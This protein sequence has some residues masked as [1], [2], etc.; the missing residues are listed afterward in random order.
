[1]S[2]A[3]FLDWATMAVSL[4]NTI[5][6]LW[7]GLTVLLNAEQRTGGVWLAGGGLLLDG[8]FFICHTV[9]LGLGLETLGVDIA[10]WWYLGWVPV[11]LSPLIWYLIMLWYAGFWDDRTSSLYRRHRIWLA[12]LVITAAILLSLLVIAPPLGSITQV[13]QLD[14]DVTPALGGI[15]VLVIIY[16]LYSMACIGL[17]IDALLRPA[18]TTRIR[19]SLA[20]RRAQR[21]LVADSAVI[22]VIVALV[23]FVMAWVVVTQNRNMITP[24]LA[25]E[26]GIL[27]AWF[28]LI[29]ASLIAVALILL[30]RA[31][32]SF[33]V[34]TGKTLPRGGFLRYW[35]NAIVLA[36]GYGLFVGWSLALRQDAIYAV[37]LTT[38][39]L[40][41]FYALA[42]WRAYRRREHFIQQ[43]RPF[44]S[45][46]SIVDQ[47]L[48]NGDTTSP[49][50][51]IASPFQM[52]C[53]DVLEAHCG[54]L[55]AVGP[56]APLMGEPIRY[57]PEFEPRQLPSITTFAGQLDAPETLCIPL[58]PT[59][60]PDFAWLIPLWS[61]R[62]LT[63][64]MLLGEK[65]RDGLYTQE[66]IEV[67]RASGERFVDT[68]ASTE[69]ARRLMTLQRRRL[70]ESQV[71]DQRTRRTVHDD[72]LPQLH[73]AILL[74]GQLD[75]PA[76]Q[77][78]V[79]ELTATFTDA[80]QQ[81][82]ELLRELPPATLPE[83]TRLGLVK[84][85][86][87]MVETE[88]AR[89]FEGIDWHVDATVVQRATALPVFATEVLYYAAREAAR[90]AARHGRGE[91]HGR[92][93]H[94]KVSIRNEHGL[95]IM[96]ED[97][98]IGIDAQ[99]KGGGQG[100]ALHSTMMAVIGGVLEIGNESG[101]GTRVTLTCPLP[102]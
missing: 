76:D 83:V 63:G 65:E 3:F 24:Q 96:I 34:F 73:T 12:I 85:L 58:D 79:S 84:A 95:S 82:S 14:F 36:A 61:E 67:A 86:Q 28:D 11:I 51:D 39:L 94:L 5:V 25:R 91:E 47:L 13:T 9:I 29:I 66:E 32:V 59:L 78:V 87:Q 100:L 20:R 33:E 43:L 17:W 15:P 97:D 30:G 21:W 16:P 6:F 41:V 92:E 31:V 57:P 2:G 89:A 72:V 23:G 4:F 93:L 75:R 99:R 70:A 52:L 54:Y 27:I 40:S 88:F 64:V 81:L 60:Y 90:N 46:Q 8:F 55:I 35:T 7:L 42:S 18:E 71:L 22:L 50:V 98:G 69:M 44:I 26:L 48:T 38:I 101:S 74:L 102:D 1:M 10:L 19:A 37:L 77:A 68:Q 49:L 62:G 45:S 80:H 56:L 53:Q